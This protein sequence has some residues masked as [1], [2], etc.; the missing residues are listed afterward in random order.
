MV[1]D[2]LHP[3]PIRI[4]SG[5]AGKLDCSKVLGILDDNR[6]MYRLISKKALG[7][8]L[9]ELLISLAILGVI[10]T[11]TIP[12]VLNAS[13][14]S[15]KNAMAKEV[16]AMIVNSQ[17]AYALNNSL[18]GSGFYEYTPYMNYVR[19]DS[20]SAIDNYNGAWAA[21]CAPPAICLRLHNGGVLLFHINSGVKYPANYSS[22]HVVYALFDPDGEY[23]GTNIGP[24]KA[25]GIWIY[26]NGRITT[27]QN[28]L[29]NTYVAGA[30][31]IAP[32]PNSDPEWFSW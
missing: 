26:A 4:Q 13:Q 16:I 25:V 10:A 31:P 1:P 5:L 30:G 3:Y 32:V 28:L 9:A 20:S 7:F 23:G 17:Q 22:T 21:S 27:P 11:F 18:V 24:S 2:L 19:V 12:K 8:T 29:P 15:Q 14:D 6:V